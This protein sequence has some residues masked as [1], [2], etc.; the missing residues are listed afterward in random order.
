MELFPHGT[1]ADILLP[2]LDSGIV[3][4]YVEVALVARAIH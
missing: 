3:L 2:A 1:L 4:Y